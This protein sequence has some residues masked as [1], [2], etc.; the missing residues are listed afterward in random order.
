MDATSLLVLELALAACDVPTRHAAR[1]VA[2]SIDASLHACVLRA[3]I[4]V[5]RA[6]GALRAWRRHG[7]RGAPRRVVHSWRRGRARDPERPILVAW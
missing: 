1:R 2:R 7:R 5:V 3:P 6:R 4:D